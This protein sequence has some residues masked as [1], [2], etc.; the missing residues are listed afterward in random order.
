MK[1]RIVGL[2]SAV[3][4]VFCTVTPTTI[5]SATAQTIEPPPERHIPEHCR[6]GEPCEDENGNRYV[7]LDDA[8]R[9]ALSNAPNGIGYSDDYGYTLTETTYS[10]I[11]A[12]DGVN[13]YID[14][15]N[16]V[17]SAISLPFSFPFYENTYDQVYITGSGYIT[18]ENYG[19]AKSEFDEIPNQS[20]PNNVIAPYWKY[21]NY[22]NLS[23]VYYKSFPDKFVVEWFSLL[24]SEDQIHTFEIILYQNGNIQFQY[25][26]LPEEEPLYSFSSAGIEDSRGSDGL[27]YWSIDEP[28]AT[29]LSSVIFT[30]PDP[31]GRLLLTPQF[32][33]KFVYPNET[34]QFTFTIKNTGDLGVDT[35]NFDVLTTWV[36]TLYDFSSG[37]PL[38]DTDGDTKIDSGPVD[39]GSQKEILVEI[40]VPEGLSV[41]AHNEVVIDA[42]SN[43]N[44]AKTKS[45]KLESTIPT[46][47]A[48]SFRD[49]I[50]SS[51]RFNLNWP[52]R[53]LA[54]NI[55]AGWGIIEPSIAETPDNKFI[56]VWEEYIEG[57]NNSEGY[58]LKYAIFDHLGRLAKPTTNLTTLYSAP[59]S[60]TSDSG[61]IAVSPDG[62]IGIVWGRTIV[63]HDGS[64]ELYNT[65]L[66]FTMMDSSGRLIFG[67]INLTNNPS[68]GNYYDHNRIFF[69]S[70]SIAATEDNRFMITWEKQTEV[71]NVEDIYYMIYNSNGSI[72]K[73]IT[74]LTN[75]PI[76]ENYYHTLSTALTDNRF[77]V[78]YN[79]LHNGH[80]LSTN[81]NYTV[82]DSDGNTIVPEATLNGRIEDIVQ[83][84][85]GNIFYAQSY[86]NGINYVILDDETYS[87]VF[88][89]N[90]ITHP[91][92][93]GFLNS[94]SV[95]RDSSDNGILTWRDEKGQYEYYAL[96]SGSD[97]ALLSG[98]YISH[99][100]DSI[101]DS[102]MFSCEQS[103]TTN[104]WQPAPGTDLFSEF[105]ADLYGAE[106]G[107]AAIL[108]LSYGN[109]ALTTATNP[110]LTLT[111]PDGLSYAGDTSGIVP[112]ISGNTVTWNLPNLEFADVGDFTVYVSVPAED[113]IGTI[114]EISQ[115]LTF[116]G[117]DIDPSNDSENVE[118]MV[119]TMTYLPL[120]NR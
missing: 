41:G 97:G 23:R 65:N 107:G 117:E 35:Y 16:D 38:T 61:Y 83:L 55:E 42:T 108:H 22:G 5:Q 27:S 75:G 51:I 54:I 94:I 63:I 80:W 116:A 21:H 6:L 33:G 113:P 62:K 32:Q 111:L 72:I 104:S 70:P 68:W 112:I 73:P 106:P 90:T 66:W 67:P 77:I 120:I 95:T 87:P 15:S 4:L 49:G 17:T 74:N 86:S 79:K 82:L 8:S 109:Q 48:Q 39:Q 34:S 7:I 102:L 115:S 31:S 85:G 44:P 119:A 45:L 14:N 105:S 99:F 25:Q 1:N 64:S 114:Y 11:D 93:N 58:I 19:W 96:V 20:L 76:N 12:S 110:Q 43:R 40:N 13:T 24:N 47:F 10:W 92:Y 29:S 18:F 101:P 57:P 28:L 84:S 98:P 56:Q 50:D 91:S 52:S 3:V 36:A 53:Q 103:V 26:E 2:I 71:D 46:S 78:S 69:G 88:I 60:Y 9:E 89:S 118:V 59:G 37:E 100:F 30:K 81:D